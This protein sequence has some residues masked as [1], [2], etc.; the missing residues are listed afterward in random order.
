[1]Q[2]LFGALFALFLTLFVVTGSY[3][4][5]P[6]PTGTCRP[7]FG[8]G[9]TCVT[10]SGLIVNKTVQNPTTK[11]FV[12]ALP[13]SASFAPNQDITFRI[14]VTN[15]N[16][17][18]MSRITI[19]DHFPQ[20]V[21]FTRGDGT[22]DTDKRTLTITLDKLA[23]NQTKTYT[24]TA[25]TM[26]E[27]SLPTNPTCLANQ[28]EVKTGLKRSTDN[29]QFCV[30][31]G[32]VQNT[33]PT[34]TQQSFPTRP[35]AQPTTQSSNQP[36]TTKGGTPVY[37]TPQSTTSP[38]TGPELLGLIALLPAGAGGILLRKKSL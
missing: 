20:Y 30:G 8:G 37:E 35:Q 11:A 19:I 13:S 25:R 31:S 29:V 14:S 5:S 16:N 33:A 4:A 36:Q 23:G 6:T 21:T 2:R 7:I 28:I 18:S 9:S 17:S 12:D 38:D 34:Q 10:S 27:D 15:N 24:V 1:M 22:F 32:S 3:A 26:G